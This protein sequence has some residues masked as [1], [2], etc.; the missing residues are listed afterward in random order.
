M[1]DRD[2]RPNFNILKSYIEKKHS[3][4]INYEAPADYMTDKFKASPLVFIFKIILRSY[5]NPQYQKWVQ[6]GKIKRL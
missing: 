6:A 5:F 1:V 3:Y 4:Y 2:T